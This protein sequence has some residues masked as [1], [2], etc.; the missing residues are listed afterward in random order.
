MTAIA[1]LGTIDSGNGH[2][3]LTGGEDRLLFLS[4]F[5]GGRWQILRHLEFHCG[6]IKALCVVDLDAA[7][8]IV[9]SGGAQSE[10]FVWRVVKDPQAKRYDP[11]VQTRFLVPAAQDTRVM[12]IAPVVSSRCSED[13]VNRVV[14]AV[15][16]SDGLVVLCAYDMQLKSAS[17]LAVLPAH[18]ACCVLVVKCIAVADRLLLMAG[19]TDGTIALYDVTEAT[20]QQ[21]QPP[22]RLPPIASKRLHQCGVNCMALQQL[23]ASPNVVLVA[24]GGDDNAIAVNAV[25]V[26]SLLV[27]FMGE[28]VVANAHAAA[29]KGIVWV[30]SSGI[31]STATDQRVQKWTY[32]QQTLAIDPTFGFVTSVT[33]VSALCRVGDDRV[34]VAGAGVELFS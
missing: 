18:E 16:C 26:S 3:F 29:V 13:R 34:V 31:V 14:I 9:F 28:A 11:T 2:V 19:G 25:R 10:V 6:A 33:D 5:Q 8:Q 32:A 12:S 24:T 7:N 15:A 17:L 20:A 4:C 23:D 30:S 21:Q 22:R 1:C 27:E